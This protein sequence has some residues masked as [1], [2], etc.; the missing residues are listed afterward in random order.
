VSRLHSFAEGIVS[1]RDRD[2]VDVI[3]H[4]CVGPNKDPMQFASISRQPKIN[5]PVGVVIENVFFAITSLQDVV[6]GTR[7]NDAPESH[8]GTFRCAKGDDSLT[9]SRGQQHKN[10]ARIWVI[11]ASVPELSESTGKNQLELHEGHAFGND[12]EG[13]E[14]VGEKLAEIVDCGVIDF[15]DTKRQ[16]MHPVVGNEFALVGMHFLD[17]VM[18][19]FQE[20]R[21]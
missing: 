16:T 4:Q 21:V 18:Q 17:H 14:T 6:R 3:V 20:G 11:Y 7:Y 8:D 12:D 15:V 5:K 1:F 13:D 19:L 10:S 9:P 2:D